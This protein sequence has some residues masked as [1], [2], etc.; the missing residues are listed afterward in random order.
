MPSDF[1]AAAN[2][3]TSRWTATL[4]HSDAALSGVG[5]WLVLATALSGA[6]G[7]AQQE[8]EAA[9]GVEK[10]AAAAS[11]CAL[12]ENLRSR[13]GIG[14]AIGLWAGSA[15]PIREGFTAALAP[16]T[17]RTLPDDAS[18]LDR[19]VRDMTGGMQD[20]FPSVISPETL[21]VLASVLAAEAD[22]VSPFSE[23]AGPWLHRKGTDLDAAALLHAESLTVSR[24]VCETDA[25][26]DVHLL[27]GAERDTPAAV[28]GL[29]IAALSGGAGFVPGSGLR[30]G[31]SG[32][33]LTVE[34]QA[35]SGPGPQ[36]HVSVP[37][38][39]IASDHDL[40]TRHEL[41]GL[42]TAMDPSHGH[43]PGISTADLAVEAAAQSALA[44][45]SARGFRAAATTAVSMLAAAAPPQPRKTLVVR[46]T[47]ERPFGF[48]VVD[49]ESGL[50]YFA[51]WVAT[52]PDGEQE[53]GLRRH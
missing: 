39:D 26:F 21:L 20:R 7:R 9:L 17:V 25:G 13:E 10:A 48:L 51:G 32:G 41:F 44:R 45:F 11:A 19:W 29:G 23:G 43:F 53:R 4:E 22:W 40:L 6:E 49:R 35:L 16:V 15:V 8:L 24:V 12:L 18:V 46:V 36:L 34:K 33:C 14:V 37:G 52:M 38:F 50:V 2:R 28:V 31:D 5:A 1:V 30:R 27:A 47:F 42:S 3:L